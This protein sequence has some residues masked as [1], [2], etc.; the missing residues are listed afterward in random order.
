MKVP[1]KRHKHFFLHDQKLVTREPVVAQLDQH[2]GHDGPKPVDLGRDLNKCMGV[3]EGRV[4]GS[5]R[6]AKG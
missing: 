6:R 3:R 4:K 5:S 1:A 2:H